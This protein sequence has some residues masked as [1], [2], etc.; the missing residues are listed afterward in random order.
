MAKDN[1]KDENEVNQHDSSVFIYHSHSWEGFLPLID[2]EDVKPSDSSST[3]K[4]KNVVLVGTMLTDK[5]KEYGINTIHN[6]ENAA[7]ALSEKGW[8][9]QNSYTLSRELV[10][11]VTSQNNNIE[12]YID[13]H[14]DSS[15]KENT[16][17]MINGTRYAR[18][19]FVVGQAHKNY[20]GNLMFAKEIHEKLEEKYPGLSR[21]VYLKS[22]SE[23]NGVYNQD[24]S[25]KSLLVE[26]GGIDN[27]KKELG[28]TVDAF[29]EVFKGVYD[30]VIEVNAQ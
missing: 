20:E 25:N 15:R 16:T 5:L 29:A 4:N 9:Y 19:Y 3:D 7:K 23:G 12:Y 14:R 26:V 8:N 30:G 18:L 11:T 2:D 17:T 10:D 22:K 6:E 21:G 28:N 1:D 13:I 27:N 24:I